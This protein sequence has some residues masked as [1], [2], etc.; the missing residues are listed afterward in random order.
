MLQWEREFEKKQRAEVEAKRATAAA[1]E[2]ATAAAALEAI[3]LVPAP[4]IAAGDSG[5]ASAPGL[6]VQ[7]ATP[8]AVGR[9]AEGVAPAA[10]AGSAGAGA[11]GVAE[12]EP[13]RR[14]RGAAVDYVA[15]NKKLEAEQASKVGGLAART[16]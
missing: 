3:L 16:L 11:G 1:A 14:R 6:E 8:A 13:K 9:A 10:A 7:H 4:P 5:P 2:R 12:P 15:L